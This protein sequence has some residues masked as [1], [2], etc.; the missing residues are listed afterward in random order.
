MFAARTGGN[1]SDVNLSVFR[2]ISYAEPKPG[3][4]QL[5]DFD[6]DDSGRPGQPCADHRRVERSQT[7]RT[8]VARYANRVLDALRPV[9]VFRGSRA[10]RDSP[11]DERSSQRYGSI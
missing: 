7:R 3:Q 6:G 2:D 4:L 11:V 1:V 8:G 9:R 5:I 10:K